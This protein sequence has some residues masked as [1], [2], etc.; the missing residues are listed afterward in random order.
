MK[1]KIVQV[2]IAMTFGENCHKERC[3][4]TTFIG[5]CDDDSIWEKQKTDVLTHGGKSHVGKWYK[6]SNIPQDDN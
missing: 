1:R 5:L 6:I 4:Y 2:A 3:K